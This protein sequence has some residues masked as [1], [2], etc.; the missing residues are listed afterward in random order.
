[1]IANKFEKEIS[2]PMKRVLEKE[3]GEKKR[4][5]MTIWKWIW[6]R[7]NYEHAKVWK[8]VDFSFSIFLANNIDL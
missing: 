4:W 1:M 5:V 3:L 7:K 8:K 2:S 6:E